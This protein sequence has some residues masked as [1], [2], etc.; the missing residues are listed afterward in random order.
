MSQLGHKRR[1]LQHTAVR[2]FPL[3]PVRDRGPVAVQYV[4]KGQLLT[5]APQQSNLF[6]RLVFAGNQPCRYLRGAFRR[7]EIKITT[8]SR[9]ARGSG[10]RGIAIAPSGAAHATRRFA[11]S[12]A[13]Q[14]IEMRNIRKA[15]L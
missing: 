14:S 6:D 11:E 1:P 9:G 4:A 5:H 13:E 2:Q 7:L 15:D 3:C 8:A 12:G 10:L